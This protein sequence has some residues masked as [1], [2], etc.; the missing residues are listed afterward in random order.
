M[1]LG[2]H[3]KEALSYYAENFKEENHIKI[4]YFSSMVAKDKKY[5]LFSVLTQC[6]SFI[7]EADCCTS[8]P[9]Y[10]THVDDLRLSPF[11]DLKPVTT[12]ESLIFLNRMPTAG[13]SEMGMYLV[14]F[15]SLIFNEDGFHKPL[16]LKVSNFYLP[17]G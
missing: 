3:C 12:S 10:R 5:Q 7:L 2:F 15:N 16:M 13:L 17:N 4:S 9:W 6:N 14:W 11:L 8:G 1:E